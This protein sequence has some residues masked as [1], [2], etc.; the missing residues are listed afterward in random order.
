MPGG[1]RAQVA[2]AWILG[3]TAVGVVLLAGAGFGAVIVTGA[4][5]ALSGA[6]LLLAVSRINGL[7]RVAAGAARE[8]AAGELAVRLDLPAN[9]QMGQFAQD[10]NDMADAIES[11][12]QL[13]SQERSRLVAVIN[14]SVD[15]TVAVDADNY[16]RFANASVFTLLEK[17][18]EEMVG[19]QFAWLV[20]NPEVIQGL[21]DCRANGE[22]SSHVIE[23]TGRRY[24]RAIVTPIEGGGE[25]MSLVVF[26]DLTDVRRTEQVRRDFV[27]NVSHELRTPLAAVKSVID[28]LQAG[29][30]RE[31]AVAEDFL[32]RADAEVDRL[33]VMVEELLMLSRIESGDLPA[34]R[35]L[36]DVSE[37]VAT[38]VE[39]LRP[40]AER[41][42]LELIL[43]LGSDLPLL[44]GDREGLERAVVNLVQ[45]AIKFTP[46]K[47]RVTVTTMA[48]RGGLLVTVT[49]TGVGIDPDDLPRVFE[50]FFKA[51]KSRRAG[52]TGLGLALVK[53]TI[54]IHGGRVEAQSDAGRGATFRFWLPAAPVDD[55]PARS[56]P[57]AVEQ[58]A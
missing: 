45:N 40:Q 24:L 57:S 33:V 9:D 47:G 25:W 6:L 20:S 32:T 15:A 34:S 53:H 54:E 55:P 29:A 28:T 5:V 48:A 41:S 21:R 23:R 19:Q 18:P 52:G 44:R 3:A 38:A 31:P 17:R 39:R 42:G 50:R 14:A 49:D 26:H 7:I 22:R 36:M 12:V 13:A 43:N 1:F 51:D 58:G 35:D 10:F 8:M 46:E 30:L 2:L 11:R 56:V 4:I 27:A 37:P 16:I